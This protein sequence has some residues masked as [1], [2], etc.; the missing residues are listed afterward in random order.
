MKN[1]QNLQTNILETLNL[2]RKPHEVIEVRLLKTKAGT[3]SGY[4]DN[5]PKL[6]QDIKPYI[7]KYD[8]YFTLN[9]VSQDLIARSA[10]RLTKYAKT[11]TSDQDIEKISYILIDLDPVRPSGIS[12]TEDEKKHAY[13]KAKDIFQFLAHY[14]WPKPIVADS[15][16][17]YHLLYSV[18]LANTNENRQLLKQF[19]AALDQLFSD[20]KTHVDKTT[21]N[22]ARIVKLYGTKACKGDSIKERPHRWSGIIS[23][24]DNVINVLEKQITE[25][26]AL[27]EKNQQT[28]E[29]TVGKPLNLDVEELIKKYDLGEYKKSPW[30]NATL[31]SL[32]KCPFNEEHD[33]SSACIIQ[34][35]N[36]A[37]CVKCHHNSCSDNNWNTLKAKLGIESTGGKTSNKASIDEENNK[38]SVSDVLLRLTQNLD[39]FSDN[40]EEAYVNIPQDNAIKVAKVKGE[41]FKKWLTKIY[42]DETGKAVTSDGLNQAINVLEAKGIF[43][44]NANRKLFQ[45]VGKLGNN[46]YYD[47]ND[48]KG[49]IVEIT[50]DKCQ[51]INDSKGIFNQIGAMSQ[52]VFPNFDVSSKK[53]IQLVVNSFN[54]KSRKDAVLY[55]IYLTTCFVPEIAHPVLIIHGQKGAA[56][57]TTM[58]F[59]RMLVDPS[60]VPL[61]SMPTKTDDLA[62]TLAKTHMVCFDNLATISAN[63]SDLL[64]MA[65]TGG[66]YAKRKLYTDDEE[67]IYSFKRCICLNGINVVATQPDLLDRSLLI[68]LDRISNGN[69][70]T[71]MDVNSRFESVQAEILG[72]CLSAISKAKVIYPTISVPNLGRMAD[73]M[74]WGYTIAEVLGIGGDN[75]LKI[76]ADNQKKS[77]AEAIESHPVASAILSFMNHRTTWTGSVASLLTSLNQVANTNGMDTKHKLWPKAPKSLSSRLREVKSNLEAVGIK[78]AIRN[79]G[80]HKE[81]TLVAER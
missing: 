71:E 7:G 37:I 14:R 44:N 39:F 70:Q 60:R 12:S 45:R 68:E 21:F 26:N 77:I 32:K 72:G 29:K 8:V 38:E 43:S 3:V 9:S 36:G 64:C 67:V 81:I 79:V 58:R 52:Q 2:I 62:G 78:Y 42:Y 13:N 51:V 35:N 50:D 49:S 30:N 33:D 59:T 19:L 41:F 61:I 28:N 34:F 17:G 6:I 22:P 31:Y 10:N 53:L 25:I 65:S 66:G 56:K 75:F 74:Y 48:G 69:Y 47:L 55:L 4:Y 54:F 27:Y 18:D 40:L 20:D 11:T 16:N 46:F 5:Y 15:G 73:F 24:P 80:T 57:S 63:F 1:V 76:Y 23:R